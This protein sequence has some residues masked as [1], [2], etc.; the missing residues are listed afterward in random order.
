MDLQR[1]D[2][3]GEVDDA[4]VGELGQGG[5]QGVDPGAQV[6]IQY[7]VAVFDQHVVVA[8]TPVGD[9]RVAVP[10][11]QDAVVAVTRGDRPGQ[12]HRAGGR[13]GP[14]RHERD[15]VARAQLAELP[16]IGADHGD[17]ADEPAQAGSVR[18]EQD[19]GVAGE[20]ERAHRIGVVVDVGRVQPGLAAVLAGPGRLGP[21]QT[22]AGTGRVE[23]HAVAGGVEG[24]DVFAGEELRGAVRSLGHRQFPVV[25]ELRTLVGLDRS[26]RVG[27]WRARAQDVAQTQRAPTMPAELAQGEG[28]GAAKIARNIETTGKG[29]IRT[30]AGYRVPNF[31]DCPGR[32]RNR[33][34]HRNF[35]AVDGQGRRRTADADQRLVAE[36]QRR[37]GGRALQPGRVRLVAQSKVGQPK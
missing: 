10:A 36:L 16:A 9:V 7:Q 33:L 12:I 11:G 25:F 34:P 20:V 8:G 3:R 17:R 2:A 24:V 14:D 22:H 37:T 27:L 19:R 21:D 1:T 31:E 6:Q 4:R 15:R 35:G 26:G 32:H 13:L 5:V 30:Q 23:V 28:G 29:D 18:P